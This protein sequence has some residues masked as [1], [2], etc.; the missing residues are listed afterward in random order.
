MEEQLPEVKEK[1][2]QALGLLKEAV[3]LSIPMLRNNQRDGVKSLWE[4]FLRELFS[5]I[6][7]KSRET[8]VN[9]LAYISYRKVLGK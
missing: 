5:Y 4:H 8:R 9:L 2:T 6:K 3:D 1:M 7:Q